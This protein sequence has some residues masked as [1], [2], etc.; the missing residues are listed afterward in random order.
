M[1]A[2]IQSGGR[3]V[4][5]S[6]GE[7]ITVDRIDAEAGQEVSIEQVLVLEKDGGE[8]LAGSPFVA[9]VRVIGVIDGESRGPKIRVFKKKRRKGMRRTKGHRSTYTRVRITDIVV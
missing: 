2:I 1:F 4:K 6:P 5:V 7:T 3:Q 9:N 8:I